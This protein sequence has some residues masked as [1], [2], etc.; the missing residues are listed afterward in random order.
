MNDGVAIIDYGCGNLQSVINAVEKMGGRAVVVNTPREINGHKKIILPGVGAF[1][2]AAHNLFATG[3][4]N[5]LIEIKNSP[6]VSILGICLGMQ[7]MCAESHEDGVH[8]GLGWFNAKVLPIKELYTGDIK[9]PHM[10]WNEI[11]HNQTHP[12]LKGVANGSDVYFVHSYCVQTDDKSSIIATTQHGVEFVSIIGKDNVV[13]M[14]FHPEKS[15][16]VGLT[17]INNF[18]NGDH[19]A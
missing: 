1:K 4:A 3:F 18:V 5:A 10:G 16:D 2:E 8:A 9:V 13:G 19:H 12:L 14:Q 11:K 6:D 17:I 7:L 15:H